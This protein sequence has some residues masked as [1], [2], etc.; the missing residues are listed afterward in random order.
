MFEGRAASPAAARLVGALRLDRFTKSFFL[1]PDSEELLGRVDV[2]QGG[3][4]DTLYP[5]YFRATIGSS[6]VPGMLLCFHVDH[7]G[8][9]AC[10][11]R[12]V[13]AVLP[14]HHRHQHRAGCSGGRHVDM[15]GMSE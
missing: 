4:G 5:L 10:R 6:I 8:P 12:A 13:P 2:C 9:Q 15:C 3:L 11:Q 14:R 1:H 7:I